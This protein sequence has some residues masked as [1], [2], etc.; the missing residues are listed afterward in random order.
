MNFNSISYVALLQ[1]SFKHVIYIYINETF[2]ISYLIQS[3][4]A[5]VGIG[6]SAC[7]HPD[8]PHSVCLGHL[9]LVFVMLCTAPKGTSRCTHILPGLFTYSVTPGRHP[10]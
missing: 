7:L 4:Y 6:H 5:L 1:I 2:Y 9:W 10:W 8:L 3:L